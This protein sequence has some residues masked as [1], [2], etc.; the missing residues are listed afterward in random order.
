MIFS[1]C[2]K[3]KIYSQYDIDKMYYTT[4]KVLRVYIDKNDRIWPN[5]KF[6]SIYC[7]YH[8]LQARSEKECTPCYFHR[9]WY[10]ELREDYHV[11][12]LEKQ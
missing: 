4:D 9:A 3:Y 10:D 1:G 8:C 5:D 12:F 2:S 7:S 6:T 11:K